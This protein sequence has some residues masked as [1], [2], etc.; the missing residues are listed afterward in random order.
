MVALYKLAFIYRPHVYI[1]QHSA[2]ILVV[3]VQSMSMCKVCPCAKFV[4]AQVCAKF[5]HAQSLSM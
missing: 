5:V 4:H 3:H 2:C 1:C